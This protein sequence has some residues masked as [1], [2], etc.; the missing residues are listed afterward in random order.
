MSARKIKW[1]DFEFV[2]WGSSWSVLDYGTSL[3]YKKLSG[4][5]IFEKKTAQISIYVK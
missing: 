3:K 1:N 2:L 4:S 5:W